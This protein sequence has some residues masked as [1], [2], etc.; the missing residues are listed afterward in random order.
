MMMV[1]MLECTTV[2]GGVYRTVGTSPMTKVGA[3]PSL[4]GGGGGVKS[5]MVLRGRIMHGLR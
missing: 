4:E 2:V 5:M 1:R 3:A